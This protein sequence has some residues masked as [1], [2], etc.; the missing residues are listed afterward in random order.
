[1]IMEEVCL[2]TLDERQQHICDQKHHR[3]S[4][5]YLDSPIA[6]ELKTISLSFSPEL[7][8]SSPLELRTRLVKV[9]DITTT[10]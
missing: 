4:S 2:F 6:E 10:S 7:C 3:M 1:M 9:T 8:P 5:F